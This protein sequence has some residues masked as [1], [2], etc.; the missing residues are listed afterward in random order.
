MKTKN[1]VLVLCFFVLLISG[2]SFVTRSDKSSEK[3]SQ[4]RIVVKE[5]TVIDGMGY[6]IVKVDSIEFLAVNGSGVVR[7][8]K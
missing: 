5:Y 8:T 3:T 6:I 2:C 7:I 4:S 1:L